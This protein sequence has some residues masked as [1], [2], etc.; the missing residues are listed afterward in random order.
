MVAAG[1]DGQPVGELIQ[2]VAVV[3]ADP[4]EADVDAP[5]GAED[6]AAFV[7]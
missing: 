7:Y 2:R 6:A 4:F 3:S 5:G 1:Q